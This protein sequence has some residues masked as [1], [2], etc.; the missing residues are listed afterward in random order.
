[1]LAT[2]SFVPG[3][4]RRIDLEACS[5]ELSSLRHHEVRDPDR[6]VAPDHQSER[7]I[8]EV[9]RCHQLVGRRIDPTEGRALILAHAP[10]PDRARSRVVSGLSVLSRS[11]SAP[12]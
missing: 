9:D 12:T 6:L 8:R 3:S 7:A 1:M 10:R 11:P 4:M 5:L 2:I